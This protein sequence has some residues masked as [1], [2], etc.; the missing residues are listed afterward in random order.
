MAE[1]VIR[2]SDLVIDVDPLINYAKYLQDQI[3]VGVGVSPKLLAAAPSWRPSSISIADASVYRYVREDPKL[4]MSQ[5]DGGP[6]G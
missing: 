4:D 3:V 5:A 1:D 2:F 6:N